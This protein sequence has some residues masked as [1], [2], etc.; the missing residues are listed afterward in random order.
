MRFW[1]NPDFCDFCKA[2]VSHDM[3]AWRM[4]IVK[5]CWAAMFGRFSWQRK[6]KLK[7]QNQLDWKSA[8]SIGGVCPRTC[9]LEKCNLADS[10]PRNSNAVLWVCYLSPSHITVSTFDDWR[11]CHMTTGRQAQNLGK[12]HNL[13]ASCVSK[14]GTLQIQLK[15]WVSVGLKLYFSWQKMAFWNFESSFQ[16]PFPWCSSEGVKLNFQLSLGPGGRRCRGRMDGE[17]R[18]LHHESRL[19]VNVS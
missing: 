15:C 4:M 3:F 19:Q 2:K 6:A 9:R 14:W 12:N 5:L 1:Q 18:L 16:S 7:I 10:S 11:L 17:A 8:N 13:L